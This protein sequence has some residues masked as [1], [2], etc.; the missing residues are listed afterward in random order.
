MPDVESVY[1]ELAEIPQ[2]SNGYLQP[3]PLPRFGIAVPTGGKDGCYTAIVDWTQADLQNNVFLKTRQTF[4]LDAHQ[5]SHT[6]SPSDFPSEVPARIRLRVPSPSARS[7]A[8]VTA[9]PKG[10]DQATCIE[11]YNSDR[12]VWNHL[13]A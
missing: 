10:D 8:F 11:I 4:L 13:V 7:L 5:Q 12:R 9:P 2:V 6:R 3:S 1:K